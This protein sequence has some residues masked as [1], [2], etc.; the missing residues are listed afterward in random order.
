MNYFNAFW[1]IDVAG[2]QDHDVTGFLNRYEC[3]YIAKSRGGDIPERELLSTRGLGDLNLQRPCGSAHK[4][5]LQNYEEADRSIQKQLF[6]RTDD[7]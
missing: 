5:I 7:F 2:F 6:P 4:K 3:R 1:N